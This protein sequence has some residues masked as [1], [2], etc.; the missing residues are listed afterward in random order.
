[1]SKYKFDDLVRIMEK[2]RAN[3][4]WDREQTHESL[5]KY[6]IEEAYEALEAID[7]GQGEK[8]ADE[9]GD[10]LLQIVFHAQIGS[11]SGEFEINDVTH[12]VCEKMIR[13]HPHV[14]GEGDAE[15]ADEVLD[16]WD[17][18]KKEEKGEESITDT[19]KSVSSYLPAL[20]RAQKVQ[21]KA[22][23]VG[24]DWDDISGALDKV[25]EEVRE[26]R[27]AVSKG[28]GMEE[29][30]GDLLFSVVNTSRFIG[31]SPEQAL[32]DATEKFIKRFEHMEDA[33][34]EGGSEISDLTPKELDKL[35]NETKKKNF[36]EKR[37]VFARNRE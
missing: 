30:L 19:L 16:N 35:W 37:R 10:L 20:M 24:F 1:M 27:D 31:T 14:F 33:A 13:R 25:N 11:E 15:S 22:A 23:K 4:P 17:E 28:Q 12:A 34:R 6:M 8:M 5:K 2:L 18:I 32:T 29:E 26:L 3:C 21:K 7:G 9:L 36:Q